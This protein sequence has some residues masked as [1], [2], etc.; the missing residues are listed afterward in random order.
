MILV[1]PKE[2]TELQKRVVLLTCGNFALIFTVFRFCFGLDFLNGFLNPFI[3][4]SRPSSLFE[5]NFFFS[6]VVFCSHA[7]F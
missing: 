7:V 5:P 6:L 4:H 1:P 2:E 3:V